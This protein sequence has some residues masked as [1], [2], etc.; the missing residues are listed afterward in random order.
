[1]PSWT[2]RSKALRLGQVS[3]GFSNGASDFLANFNSRRVKALYPKK[4]P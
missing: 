2:W 3:K 1:M 4:N